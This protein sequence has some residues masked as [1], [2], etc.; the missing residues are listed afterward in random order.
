[1]EQFIKHVEESV[2]IPCHTPEVS[3]VQAES[4]ESPCHM[5]QVSDVQAHLSEE[6]AEPHDH[7]SEVLSLPR[8][9]P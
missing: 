7:V 8:V 5:P 2:E 6:S 3:D 9:V 4:V 1:M